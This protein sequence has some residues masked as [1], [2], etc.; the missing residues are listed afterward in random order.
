MA[1]E[2][3]SQKTE[4]PTERKLRKARDKGQVAQSQEVKTWAVLVGGAAGLF[5][6]AP[7]MANQLRIMLRRFLESPDE[8]PWSFAHLH[9]VFADVSLRLLVILGPFFLLLMILAIAGNIVQFGLL[10]APEKLVPDLSK[11]SLI[12]GLQRMFAVRALVEFV[13][14]VLKLFVVGAVSAMLAAPMLHD[15]ALVPEFS[16]GAILHRV[17][18]ISFR[19]VLGALAV[20]SVIAVIDWLYQKYSFTKQMRMSKQELKDEHKQSEGDPQIKA[21]IRRLRQE[22]AQ[23]RM[24]AA[25]PEADVVITNPTHYA[26]ALS[27]KMEEM[28]APK[29]VAKGVDVLAF[30]IRDIAKAHDVPVVENPPLAR[31]LYATV[32]LDEEIPPE[33]FRAVAEVIGYVMRLK[34]KIPHV[35][36]AGT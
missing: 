19:I 4:E 2:D 26:V 14:G 11:L 7:S 31:A 6:L 12:K 9:Q 28:A 36:R 15:V 27:Y 33:H 13:K 22:R 29:L 16:I 8:I 25:V 34:G 23:R 17:D 21:R 1:E 30:R 35:A 24:M 18:A 3:D 10:L 20:M 32:E 5:F